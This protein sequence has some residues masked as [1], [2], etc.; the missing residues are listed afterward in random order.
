V[1]LYLE[2]FVRVRLD[3]VG[4][5]TSSRVLVPL[6]SGSFDGTPLD[7]AARLC[8]EDAARRPEERSW[9]LRVLKDPP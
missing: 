9:V 7:E 8:R 3:V 5:F 6:T 4:N 2:R 1:P